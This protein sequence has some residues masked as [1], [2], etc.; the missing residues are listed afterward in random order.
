MTVPE[1]ASPALIAGPSRP[2]Q[3]PSE[4][5]GWGRGSSPR[6]PVPQAGAAG[7]TTPLALAEIFRPFPSAHRNF[8][9]CS[10]QLPRGGAGTSPLTLYLFPR[11]F[12][13]KG[14]IKKHI[15]VKGS[16]VWAGVMTA[17][18]SR[19]I[20]VL[21]HQPGVLA[22][23]AGSHCSSSLRS[24]HPRCSSG[25]I[26]AGPPLLRAPFPPGPSCSLFQEE[27]VRGRRLS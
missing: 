11:L 16:S 9:T 6:S 14:K 7:A 21:G 18:L 15:R 2:W 8:Q 13:S 26:P 25:P 19:R 23:G 3:R 4:R 5:R 20:L 12:I 17:A 10:L 27:P 24:G 1:D 22:T